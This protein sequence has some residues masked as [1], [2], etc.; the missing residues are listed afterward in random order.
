M[1]QNL[2]LPPVAPLV[3]AGLIVRPRLPQALAIPGPLRR[4]AM[5]V[6]DLFGAMG[7]V[8]LVPLVILAIGMPIVLGLRALLWV[9]GLF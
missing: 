6:G 4:T 7:V 1:V 2:A 3:D 5:I 8:L 9:V